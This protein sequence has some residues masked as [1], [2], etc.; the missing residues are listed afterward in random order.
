M[1]NFKFISKLILILYVT[2]YSFIQ[3]HAY[4]NEIKNPM[5]EMKLKDGL[6][7]IELFPDVAPK[8]V[9]RILENFMT[10]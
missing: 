4:N 5:L 3:I 6:V 9:A 10:E 1:N 8:H 2:F 7:L